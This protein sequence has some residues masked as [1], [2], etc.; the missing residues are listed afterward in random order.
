MKAKTAI[1]PR[2]HTDEHG[3][4]TVDTNFTNSHEFL[5][6]E[7]VLICTTMPQNV[8]RLRK[9][10]VTRI[11]NRKDTKSAKTELLSPFLCAL[12][13][14]AVDSDASNLVSAPLLHLIRSCPVVPSV[15]LRV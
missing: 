12:R 5:A 6:R 15:S 14:F 8:C 1:K 7:F 10:L 13:V 2:M 4:E 9:F 3:W 11:S